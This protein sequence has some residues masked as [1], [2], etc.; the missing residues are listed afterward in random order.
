M[1]NKKLDIYHIQRL[2]KLIEQ[3]DALDSKLTAEGRELAG[4]RKLTYYYD[5]EAFIDHVVERINKKQVG[6]R[7]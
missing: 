4:L 6:G 2:D 5:G 1:K 7:Q 3:V